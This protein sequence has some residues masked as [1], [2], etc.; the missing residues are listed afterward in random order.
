M[1]KSYLFEV[2]VGVN[3]TL[4]K[5]AGRLTMVMCILDS[6]DVSIDEDGDRYGQ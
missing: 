2:Y 1:T 6:A 5:N 3:A 4:R